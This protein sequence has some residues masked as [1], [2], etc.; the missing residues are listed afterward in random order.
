VAQSERNETSG[1][2]TLKTLQNMAEA[3]GGRFVYAIVPAQETSRMVSARAE[4]KA[5]QLVARTDTHMALEKQSLNKES[6]AFE[7]ERL[8][9]E[10]LG[11]MPKDLWDDV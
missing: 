7:I 6:R 1:A 5:R 11:K 4:E 10:L 3:M 8:K 2:V 9:Q